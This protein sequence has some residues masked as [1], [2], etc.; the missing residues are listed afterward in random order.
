MSEPLKIQ[1]TKTTVTEK[2]R[3]LEGNWKFIQRPTIY[4]YGANPIGKHPHMIYVGSSDVPLLDDN[5]TTVD[6]LCD[7]QI[8]IDMLNHED[9][10][11]ITINHISDR[12]KEVIMEFWPEEFMK[13]SL[14]L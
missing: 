8:I 14:E 4:E 10:K 1:V 13:F 11:G 7:A 6:E 12:M 3:K 5:P 9:N 2:S